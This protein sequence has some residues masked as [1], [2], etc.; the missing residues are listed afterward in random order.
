MD[1]EWLSAM[2]GATGVTGA[3]IAGLVWRKTAAKRA[4][5]GR[6]PLKIEVSRDDSEP[7]PIWEVATDEILDREDFLDV[8]SLNEDGVIQ[9]NRFRSA[10]RSR[11]DVYDVE[12]TSLNLQI[13]NPS[14]VS[15]WITEIEANIEERRSAPAG[16]KISNPPQGEFPVL[17]LR[18]DLAGSTCRA[19]DADGA[20]YFAR[21]KRKI[22][23]GGREFIGFTARCGEGAVRWRLRFDLLIGGQRAVQVFPPAKSTPL[24]TSARPPADQYQRSWVCSLVTMGHDDA[25]EPP[26]LHDAHLDLV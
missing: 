1:V 21:A 5:L 3:S 17:E 6:T 20:D 26:Y 13:F 25:A 12:E 11:W 19:M 10:A 2:A 14:D 4:S 8:Y 16:T 15:V 18:M 24:L 9:P 23:P 22:A 7:G